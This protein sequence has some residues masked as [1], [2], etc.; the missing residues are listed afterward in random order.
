MLIKRR[1]MGKDL[2]GKEL[3]QGIVQRKNGRYDARFVDRF[4]KRVSVSGND[5]KDVKRRYNEALYE[6]EKQINI[7]QSIKLDEWYQ[8]WLNVY[9]FDVI[10]ENTRKSYNTVY[11]KHISPVLG[12][13]CLA[14]IN[15]LQIK[16]LIK[17]LKEDGYGYET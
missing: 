12:N 10:R 7:K 8:E 5:L 15:Q 3:G 1:F 4:G 13:M 16:N 2:N 14:D 11:I 9:K 6:N 17:N